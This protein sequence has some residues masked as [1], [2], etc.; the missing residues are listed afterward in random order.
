MVLMGEKELQQPRVGGAQGLSFLS[1]GSLCFNCS[2]LN[3]F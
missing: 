3:S 1:D 2:K